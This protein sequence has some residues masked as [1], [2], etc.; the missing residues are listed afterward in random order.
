MH[1]LFV[2][3]RPPAAVR[4]PLLD[5]M[6]GVRGARWQDEE[7]LHLTL[8]FV[9][10]VDRHQAEDVAAALGTI[11]HPRFEI[12][13][14]GIGSFDRR[15]QP[16]HLWVG[17][18]PHDPLKTLHNKV[19]QALAHAGVEPDRRAY[20]P[21]ITIARLNRAT[22]PV[23]ALLAAHGGITS[24][25]FMVDDFRLYESDLAADGAIYSVIQR[26][27]LGQA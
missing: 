7:Q 18:A 22:G 13:L 23:D 19:D 21:H 9:G 17:V 24:A 10:E 25:P 14:A 20:L 26:Y 11:H 15:G 16:T 27:P 2:A 12:A 6:E 8:R 1:R 4:E 3:I 5:L